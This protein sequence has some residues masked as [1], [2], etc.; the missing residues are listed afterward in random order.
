MGRINSGRVVMAGVV[1]GVVIGVVSAVT[2]PMQAA[3]WRATMA[4]LGT[5][6]PDTTAA[7]MAGGI[8]V[9]LALGILAVWLY[10]AIRPRYGPGPLTAAI[11]GVAVWSA[12]LLANLTWVLLANLT[13][14]MVL[15]LHGPNIITL[16]LATMAGAWLY[17]E[18]APEMAGA[19]SP[20]AAW[21]LG[22]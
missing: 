22:G 15:A 12:I 14:G 11:A 17:R 7:F 5:R 6:F 3:T 1:A 10:A 20:G 9:Q 16:A 21:P 4:A 19:R 8:A 18:D 13:L 2:I